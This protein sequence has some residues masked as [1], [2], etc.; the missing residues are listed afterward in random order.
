MT[1]MFRTPFLIN[2]ADRKI[3]LTYFAKILKEVW[4]LHA[5]RDLGCEKLDLEWLILILLT[6]Y[7][8][9]EVDLLD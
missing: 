9:F 2:M 1:Q 4:L 3:L 7:R 5:S 8:V 6:L